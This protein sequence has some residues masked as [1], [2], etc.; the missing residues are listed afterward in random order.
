MRSGYNKV[1][2]I[3]RYNYYTSQFEQFSCCLALVA[4]VCV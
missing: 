3:Y 1:N 2:Q 4:R